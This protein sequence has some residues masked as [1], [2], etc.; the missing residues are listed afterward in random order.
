MF[1]LGVA[2]SIAKKHQYSWDYT[3]DFCL[4]HDLNL[5]QFYWQTPFPSCKWKNALQIKKRYLHLDEIAE[6]DY[7]NVLNGCQ[8]F[9][10]YYDSNKLIL[11]QEKTWESD[12]LC[13][14]INRL[15]GQGFMVGIENHA[16]ML[17]SDFITLI[18]KCHYL[19][20]KIF[21]VLDVH[22]FFH[23]FHKLNSIEKILNV[24]NRLLLLCGQLNL[25]LV[26]HIIDSQSFESDRDS[27]CPLFNGIVPYRLVFDIISSNS[28]HCEGMILEYEDDL[29]TLESINRFRHLYAKDARE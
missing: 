15:N 4:H 9:K 12:N 7:K 8:T 5:I 25:T 3:I 11:H 27:W 17:P 18:K 28:I 26:L 16:G 20:Q 2:T 14:L 23:R 10:Q 19:G 6:A 21:V 29:N 13:G 1:E 24:L 22:K